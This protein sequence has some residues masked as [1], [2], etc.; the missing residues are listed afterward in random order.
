MQEGGINITFKQWY[1]YVQK[2]KI[3]FKD[4]VRHNKNIFFFVS[5]LLSYSSSLYCPDLLK[6]INGKEEKALKEAKS[7]GVVTA[8]SSNEELILSL[9]KRMLWMQL[10]S[11]HSVQILL[12]LHRRKN[13]LLFWKQQVKRRKNGQR[14]DWCQCIMLCQCVSYMATQIWEKLLSKKSH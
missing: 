7:E 14:Q 5:T 4:M 10:V 8:S 9:M 6:E 1:H 3:L 2:T 11:R 12:N 13:H